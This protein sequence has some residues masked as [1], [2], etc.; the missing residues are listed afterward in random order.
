MPT[1]MPFLNNTFCDDEPDDKGA[2][3]DPLLIKLLKT[4]AVIISDPIDA[5]LTKAVLTQLLLLDA[6]DPEAEIRIFINSPGGSADSGFS[7]FDMIRFV[8]PPV[9]TICAGLVASAAAM[10]L[11]AAKKENRVAFPN[12]RI[13]LHQPSMSFQGSAADIEITA[14]QILKLKERANQIIAQETGHPLDRIGKDTNRDHWMDAEEAL[15]YN[16]ISKIIS[17]ANEI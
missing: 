7:I 15:E 8:R 17:S 12:S 14:Q 11:L 4:R 1:E 16:L 5:R 10:I 6:D 9:K 3:D 13:L 2:K